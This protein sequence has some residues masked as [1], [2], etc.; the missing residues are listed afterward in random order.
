MVQNSALAQHSI[1]VHKTDPYLSDRSTSPYADTIRHFKPKIIFPR[2]LLEIYSREEYQAILAHEFAHI[3]YQ[4]NLCNAFI[5]WLEGFLWFIPFH[6][7]ILAKANFF[8]ELS[9]DLES[10]RLPVIT[11]LAKT[12]NRDF[13]SPTLIAFSSNGRELS[14][15]IESLT[16]GKRCSLPWLIASWIFFCGGAAFIFGSYFLPF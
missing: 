10:K 4:D 2:K 15:R 8:R 6:R 9:C 14:R 11:A 12:Q 5:F 1:P 13:I 16:S 3:R 7:R